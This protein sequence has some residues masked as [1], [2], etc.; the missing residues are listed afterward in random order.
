[1]AKK[2]AMVLVLSCCALTLFAGGKKEKTRTVE[3][4]D[5]F[6]PIAE[7]N[8]TVWDKSEKDTGVKI[9]Y[10]QFDAAKEAEA[11]LVAYNA[12]SCPD[13]FSMVFSGT[14]ITATLHNEGWFSPMNVKKEELP[15]IVQNSLFEG[16]STFDGKVYSFPLYSINHNASLWY[17]TEYV[18]ENEV[19]E[20]FAEARALAKKITQS[21]G[22]KV[23]GFVIPLAFTGRM[24]DTFEDFLN[25]LGSDGNINWSTGA[26]N[27][28][29]PEMFQI[30]EFFTGL[31]DDGSVLPS[32]VNMV[33]RAARER[34]AAGE[35]AMLIDGSWNIGVV[36]TSFNELYN[37][38]SV[39]VSEA[40]RQTKGKQYKVYKN[41]PAGV[42]YISSQSDA[43]NEA[44]NALLK[45]M[46]DEYY[47][48]LAE[49]QDQ[50]PLNL[51]V[52]AKAN[53]D[54]TYKK[55]CNIFERTMYY[56]PDPVLRNVNVAKVTAEMNEIHPNPAEILQGY[57]AG[58][59]T[60]WRAEL[61]KYNN[62]MTAERERAIKKCQDE[63]VNVSINDWIFT[64]YKYGENYLT[65]LYA[66]SYKK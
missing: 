42:F 25:V 6:L 32:S 45:M 41:P 26:Y 44:T 60:D 50:P 66:S 29:S 4:W 16:Y 33:M 7:L 21:S 22:G 55:I 10:T 43:V 20:T 13:V 5:H 28:A 8:R 61:V 62:A 14:G 31:W 2:L 17:L 48:G 58:S 47:I 19:P 40:L 52:V 57:C 35:G 63:G 64:N 37:N 36:K 56:K 1:M 9:E 65:N 51:S 3:W 18:K 38:G 49:A 24:N 11:L 53:V 12:N 54:P 59:I 27:Y 34:W 46:G 39:G 30:F 23:Y 15:S